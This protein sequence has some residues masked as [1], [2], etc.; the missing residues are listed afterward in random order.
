MS[1]EEIKENV[2]CAL[3]ELTN[4]DSPR[5]YEVALAMTYLQHILN[6]LED[7]K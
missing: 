2:S 4:I 5:P 7:E 3:G 1:K 6:E